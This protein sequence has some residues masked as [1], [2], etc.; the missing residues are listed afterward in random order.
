MTVF[1]SV[2]LKGADFFSKKAKKKTFNMELFFFILV[3][4]LIIAGG[5]VGVWKGN[6]WLTYFVCIFAMLLGL[7]LM[8]EGVFTPQVTTFEITTTSVTPNYQHIAPDDPLIFGLSWLLFGGG[9]V[10][11]VLTVYYSIN[12]KG[13]GGL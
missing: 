10:F 6:Q 3:F 13:G 11:L 4:A 1:P 8:T 5:V 12:N 9:L 7:L 2:F